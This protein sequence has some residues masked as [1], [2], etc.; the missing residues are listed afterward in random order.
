LSIREFV[1]FAANKRAWW[2]ERQLIRRL[3]IIFPAGALI[4]VWPMIRELPPITWPENLNSWQLAAAAAFWI[5]LGAAPGYL[6]VWSPTVL[7]HRWRHYTD[8]C[9]S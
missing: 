8:T 9:W 2:R 5:G 1:A 3:Y 6:Y 4:A 7:W